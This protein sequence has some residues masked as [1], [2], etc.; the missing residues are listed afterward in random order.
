MVRCNPNT[1]H[2]LADA[3]YDWRDNRIIVIVNILIASTAW[4]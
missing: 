2:G 1:V 3:N 4:A